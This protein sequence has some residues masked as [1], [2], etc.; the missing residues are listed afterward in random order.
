MLRAST[1]LIC[2]VALPACLPV[3]TYYQE[4]ASL[5][6]IQRAQT[7]CEVRALRDAPVAQVVRQGPARWVPGART[8]NASG[9]CFTAPGRYV[10]GPIT[11]VDVNADLRARVEQ[12]CMADQGFTP[13]RIPACPPG[14]QRA[15]PP[16]A[17]T[18]LPR[19]TD[20]VSYT[21]LTLPTIC[22]V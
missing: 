15:A 17:T 16:G 9:T 11:T 8:C 3:S 1:F 7:A 14:I 2:L 20:A 10:P 12:Q 13:A 18:T 5:A 19:L 6:L 21:H 22:S 4:G